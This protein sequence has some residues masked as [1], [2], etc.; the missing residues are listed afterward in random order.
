MGFKI[1]YLWHKRDSIKMKNEI[2][3]C[4]T[5]FILVYHIKGI[6]FFLPKA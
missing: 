2:K 5:Y 4:K 6:N 1:K 3:P